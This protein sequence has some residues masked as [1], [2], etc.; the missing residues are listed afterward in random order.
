[1][2]R[3]LSQSSA[4]EDAIPSARAQSATPQESLPS[5]RAAEGETHTAPLGT[6]S[7]SSPA[8]V[9]DHEH[10]SHQSRLAV[11]Q[12]RGRYQSAPASPRDFQNWMA[13]QEQH[14]QATSRDPTREESSET[15]GI[16]A[17]FSP[18]AQDMPIAEMMRVIEVATAAGDNA[19][20]P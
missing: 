14:L 7:P 10:A 9:P 13:K 3:A 16:S 1:M 11:Y 5:P 12:S 4:N 17:V 20:A 18:G 8:A 15:P 2:G 19:P 6:A